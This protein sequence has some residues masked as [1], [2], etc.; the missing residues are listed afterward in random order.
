MT[1]LQGAIATVQLGKLKE[2]IRSNIK[3]YKV[4]QKQLSA[5]FIIRKIPQGSKCINDTFILIQKN[6]KKRAKIIKLLNEMKF[7]TKNL[8]DAMEWH[9]SYFWDHAL[10]KK[11]V[12]RSKKSFEILNNCIAIPILRNKSIKQYKELSLKIIKYR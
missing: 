5:H 3:R 11:Q 4:L 8:P 1:E 10:P 9:C 6:K 2:M 12:R 7:G